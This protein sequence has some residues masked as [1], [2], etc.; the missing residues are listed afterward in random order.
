MLYRERNDDSNWY[1]DVVLKTT[2]R[3][4]GRA[5]PRY[6]L[7]VKRL[8]QEHGIVSVPEQ[9]FQEIHIGDLLFILP[10]HSCLTADMYCSYTAT[11]G[12]KIKKT[13][14]I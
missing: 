14:S 13:R 10:V 6:D 5:T 11:N 7:L 12:R 3:G 9:F 1:L 4:T 8:S 2:L